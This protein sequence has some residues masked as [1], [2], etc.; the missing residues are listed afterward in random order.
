[1]L[2]INQRKDIKLTILVD[3][4][5]VN[6]VWA[7]LYKAPSAPSIGLFF[8]YTNHLKGREWIEWK[9]RG[10]RGNAEAITHKRLQ[11]LGQ[12]RKW[13]WAELHHSNACLWTD[14]QRPPFTWQKDDY[15]VVGRPIESESIGRPPIAHKFHWIPYN[16]LFFSTFGGIWGFFSVQQAYVCGISSMQQEYV[17]GK[18]WSRARTFSKKW[19]FN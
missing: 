8:Q 18:K 14:T 7:P 4:R 15:S 9:K 16:F 11:M 12:G 2:C 19:F 10:W 13:N 5:S 1:M 17:R 6:L 3:H